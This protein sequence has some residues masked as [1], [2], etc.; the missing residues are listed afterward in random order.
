MVNTEQKTL[1]KASEFSDSATGPEL[2]CI[3]TLHFGLVC[4]IEGIVVEKKPLGFCDLL[5]VLL[6]QN[7]IFLSLKVRLK[8]FSRM[9]QSFLFI[10]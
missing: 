2:L 1:F 7:A 8:R 6:D 4:D 5:L 3:K 9:K 10:V